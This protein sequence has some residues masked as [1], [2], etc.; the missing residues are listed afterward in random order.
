MHAS[1]HFKTYLTKIYWAP[2]LCW[3]LCWKLDMVERINI[4]PNFMDLTASWTGTF[5]LT[6]PQVHD[7]P[8]WPTPVCDTP[9]FLD[10]QRGG[11]DRRG[12]PL[13]WIPPL[14]KASSTWP[15]PRLPSTPWRR[16]LPC[17]VPPLNLPL[18]PYYQV[19]CCKMEKSSCD[20]GL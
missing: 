16:W 5:K 11:L 18:L 12:P 15:D 7:F 4:I 2:N 6:C 20:P 19:K 13:S 8:P 1:I 3:A 9:I 17:W 10:T 14:P